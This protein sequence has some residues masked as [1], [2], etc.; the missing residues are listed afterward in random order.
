MNKIDRHREGQAWTCPMTA[1]L[2]VV[3][4]LATFSIKWAWPCN[5]RGGYV[6]QAQWLPQEGFGLG[7]ICCGVF[8][9][10]SLEGSKAP[11]R[12]SPGNCSGS[13]P[14]N[15]CLH[16]SLH[17][18]PDPSSPREWLAVQGRCSSWCEDSELS[19]STRSRQAFYCWVCYIREKSS[20]TYTWPLVP[21]SVAAQR[22]WSVKDDQGFITLDTGLH[23]R[24][25][26]Q[27]PFW[28]GSQ[29]L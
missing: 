22:R 5:R 24:L 15:S 20:R 28:D 27:K 14:P 10:G 6:T 9:R 3:K 16:M 29:A 7:G 2:T 19:F 21:S 25:G 4:L 12:Q 23:N 8:S 11:P 13:P 1:C 17:F 26:Q 18:H